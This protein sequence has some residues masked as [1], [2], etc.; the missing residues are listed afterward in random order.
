MDLDRIS[1][2]ALIIAL[3]LLVDD[4]IIAIE[5]MIVKT[6]AGLDRARGGELCLDITAF[7]MLTGTL[8]TVGRIHPVGFAKSIAAEYAGGIFWVVGDRA[9]RL[10]V[11]GRDLHA[12][13]RAD[14]AVGE[15]GAGRSTS[16]Y[17]GRIPTGR[18][19][20]AAIDACLRSARAW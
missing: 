17:G 5:M 2:G 6:R 9:D 19:C 12:L 18:C 13:S 7:P 3:G 20:R 10:M 1:L 11:R 4:A 8:V 15:R 14:A 16:R